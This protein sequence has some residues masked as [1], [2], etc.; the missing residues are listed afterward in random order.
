MLSRPSIRAA[1]VSLSA[2]LLTAGCSAPK[3]EQTLRPDF[4]ASRYQKVAV[5]GTT[6]GGST[7]AMVDE[8]L[9]RMMG[10]GIDVVDSAT[11]DAA[12]T[13]LGV[14]PGNM[15]SAGARAKVGRA[16][17]AQGIL[18]INYTSDGS[19]VLVS[20][21]L[22]DVDTSE[23]VWMAQGEG[24][25][26]AGLMGVAGAAVGAAVGYELGGGGGAVVGGILAGQGTAE[27]APKQLETAKD[28]VQSLVA[29]MPLS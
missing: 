12:Q 10:K 5:V 1:L 6:P 23:M 16:L 21:K 19:L 2:L 17:G 29:A 18:V 7:Q 13:K 9:F 3:V 8:F 22:F 27:L 26:R 4:Q 28:V 25:V 11:L 14:G 24:K 15:E 20:A